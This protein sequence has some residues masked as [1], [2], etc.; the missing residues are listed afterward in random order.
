MPP[1]REPKIEYIVVYR[2]NQKYK[3]DFNVPKE[4]GR[5]GVFRHFHEAQEH[6]AKCKKWFNTEPYL[7]KSIGADNKLREDRRERQH[8]NVIVAIETWE[9]GVF[10]GEETWDGEKKS[11]KEPELAM[12]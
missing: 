3:G 2:A 9:D 1:I 12:A 10:K 11:K 7:V 5:H 8:D 6:A 4:E